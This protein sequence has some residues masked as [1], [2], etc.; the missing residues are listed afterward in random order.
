MALSRKLLEAAVVARA[1]EDGAF[2]AKLETDPASAL[3]EAGIPQPQGRTI[4]VIFE[5]PGTTLIA[6]AQ[7]PA[8]QEEVCDEELAEVAGGASA[9]TGKCNR[10]ERIESQ[11]KRGRWSDFDAFAEKA[12]VIAGTVIGYSWAWS[13]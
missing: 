10:W 5:E 9:S 4:R 8:P 1:W 2:R 7:E 6:L 13:A 11:H 3:A 12:A